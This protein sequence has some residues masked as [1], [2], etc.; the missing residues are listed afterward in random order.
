MQKKNP[1]VIIVV[2][3]PLLLGA[4]VSVLAQWF[5]TPFPL[6]VFGKKGLDFTKFSCPTVINGTCKISATD[7]STQLSTSFANCREQ[8]QEIRANLYSSATG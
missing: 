7:T 8:L 1:V 2:F 5:W 4:L 3:L 6:L